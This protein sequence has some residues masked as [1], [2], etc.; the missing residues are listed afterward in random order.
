M[1]DTAVPGNIRKAKHFVNFLRSVIEHIRTRMSTEEVVLEPSTAFVSRFRD[2]TKLKDHQIV[3]LKFTH[4]RLQSLF[5]TLQ[6]SDLDSYTPLTV[7]SNFASLGI[8]FLFVYKCLCICV[9]ICVTTILKIK[10]AKLKKNMKN[11]AKYE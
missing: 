4:D 1:M 5:R 10:I 11:T 3:A 2:A 7:I 6:I 9:C 8:P